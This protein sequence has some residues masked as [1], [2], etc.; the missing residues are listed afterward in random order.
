MLGTIAGLCN[1]IIEKLDL[2]T[3]YMCLRVCVRVCVR[4]KL[5]PAGLWLRN[6]LV[7]KC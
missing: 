2:R 5:C 3:L 6:T 1:C 7:E 4:E